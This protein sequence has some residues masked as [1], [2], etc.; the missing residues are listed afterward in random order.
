M[1][2]KKEM[3]L[4]FGQ[5]G[6]L[7]TGLYVDITYSGILGMNEEL[8]IAYSMETRRIY[9][10]RRNWNFHRVLEVQKY[11]QHDFENNLE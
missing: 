9:H 10:R 11:L 5:V 2:Y 7:S 4:L 3:L 6:T 1:E 8:L